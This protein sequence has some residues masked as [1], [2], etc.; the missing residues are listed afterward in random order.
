MPWK[1]KSELKLEL[2]IRHLATGALV[3]LAVRGAPRVPS[4]VSAETGPEG[5][6]M[7]G[8]MRARDR[9]AMTFGMEPTVSRT[10][11][12]IGLLQMKMPLEKHI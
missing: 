4:V 10:N 1:V 9:V 8:C 6:S 12:R 2:G 3:A 5:A 7:L 11:Q